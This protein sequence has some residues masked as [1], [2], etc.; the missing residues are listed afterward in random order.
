MFKSHSP[1]PTPKGYAYVVVG[2]L[3]AQSTSLCRVLISS[4]AIKQTFELDTRDVCVHKLPLTGVKFGPVSQV[5]TRFHRVLL[6][7]L[8]S[9]TCNLFWIVRTGH[10]VVVK[11]W[12]SS[13]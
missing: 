9:T 1:T 8:F 4:Q 7:V 11:L 12:L 6:Y 3:T 2:L 5:D 10:F 13:S